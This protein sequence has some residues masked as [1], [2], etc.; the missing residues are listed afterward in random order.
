MPFQ[1]HAFSESE[2]EAG[3]YAAKAAISDPLV[4]TSGDL[5]YIPPGMNFLLGAYAALGGTTEGAAYL[6][7]PSL[8]RMLLY[9]IQPTEEGIGPSGDESV[10]I[11][12]EY[13]IEL[14]EFEGLEAYVKSNPGSAEVHTVVPFLATGAI[15]PLAA[16]QRIYTVLF[17]TSITETASTW[18]NG[19]ITFR[20]TLPVGRY[21]IVGAAMWGTSGVAFRF[22]I[23]GVAHRPGFICHGSEGNHGSPPQRRGGMGVWA[24]FHSLTPPSVDWLAN[25][26]SGSSQTGVMDLIKVA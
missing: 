1:I 5:L 26:T 20:Q 4:T 15:S 25:A 22:T 7:S 6:Q 23:P 2:D 13:P 11:H 10:L 12:P 18:K 24:E 8:K 3:A 19:A 21:Q 16:G 14:D 9:D 17:T